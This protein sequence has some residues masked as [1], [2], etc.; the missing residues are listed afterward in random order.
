MIPVIGADDHRGDRPVRNL[1]DV[2]DQSLRF[3]DTSLAVGHEHPVVRDDE[4]ADGGEAL[5]A[6]RAQLL[7]G[8]DAGRELEDARKVVVGVATGVRVGGADLLVRRNLGSGLGRRGVGLRAAA[9]REAENERGREG[10]E[11]V[12][13]GWFPGL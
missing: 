3:L 5:V 9:R 12:R 13:H 6:C 4:Q 2:V 8:V 10:R 11:S 1:A 7:V